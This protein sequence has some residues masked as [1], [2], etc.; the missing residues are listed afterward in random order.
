MPSL[1]RFLI[2]LLTLSPT[3]LPA[4]PGHPGPAEHSDVTHLIVGLVVALPA[5][6]GFSLWR[7]HHKPAV[8]K[9]SKK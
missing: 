7:R 2:I 8:E 9:R 1:K 3:L 5:L 4:H 6:L